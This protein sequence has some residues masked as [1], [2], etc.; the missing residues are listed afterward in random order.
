MTPIPVLSP[1][2]TVAEFHRGYW[3]VAEL[4]V[5]AKHIGVP[6]AG[7]LRKDQ[8]ERAIIEFL[9]T[10]TIEAPP[11]RARFES[12]VRDVARGLRLNLPVVVYTN[13]SKT[14]EFLEREARKLEPQYARRSGA[15]YRLNRWREQQAAAGVTI[16]Y[17][18]LVTEYVRLSLSAGTFAQVPHGR[19]I[20]FISDFMACESSPTM[21]NAV[22]AWKQLKTLDVPKDYRSWRTRVRASPS[23]RPKRS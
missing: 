9:T 2:M 18:D 13:D 6:S 10:Q 17:R 20:N 23:A 8:L 15:R 21:A 1:S 7:Q 14:K 5:F 3:Y 12:D 19:Y 11:Q 4:K 22:R 16:T